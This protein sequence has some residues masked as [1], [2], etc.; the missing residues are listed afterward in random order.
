LIE[1][2]KEDFKDESD[3]RFIHYF[4]KSYFEEVSGSFKNLSSQSLDQVLQH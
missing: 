2:L 3:L 4:I 1:I